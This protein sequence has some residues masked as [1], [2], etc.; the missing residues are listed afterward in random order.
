[1]TTVVAAAIVRGDPPCVLGAERAY[2][3]RLAGWWELPGGKVHEGEGDVAA[4]KRECREELGVEVEVGERVGEDIAIA[5]GGAVLRVWWASI[6]D[7][8]PEP[9]EHASLRWLTAD[10]LDDVPW[11]PADVPIIDA[12]RSGLGSLGD[13]S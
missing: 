3:P 1:M 10:E 12:I 6:T 11:L 4:L 5:E 2:P 7:G 13:H 8:A 9:R